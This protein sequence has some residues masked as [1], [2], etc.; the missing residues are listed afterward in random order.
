MSLAQQMHAERKARL[1]R[2]GAIP[3]NSVVSKLTE[4]QIVPIR[5]ERKLIIPP[6]EYFYPSF[7]CW[8]LITATNRI[9]PTVKNIQNVVANHFDISVMDMVSARRTKNLIL[10][11]HVALYLA[12]EMT[13]LSYPVIGRYFGG[14]D[15]STIIHAVEKITARMESEPELKRTVDGL[16]GLFE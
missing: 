10:P 5:P 14:R 13:E 9:L 15:H 7:W 1:A 8:D 3:T 2:L 12:K 6:V 16:R 4:A 11:R